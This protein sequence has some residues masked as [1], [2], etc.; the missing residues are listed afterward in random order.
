MHRL[1]GDV[2]RFKERL[3]AK[4]C[5]KDCVQ[6]YGIDFAPIVHFSTIGYLMAV[7]VEHNLEIDQMDTVSAFLQENWQGRRP[8][9]N[10]KTVL[11]RLDAIKS[12]VESPT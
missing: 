7:T 2:G 1:D 8:I 4:V 6:R 5:S 9:W 10:N 11:S 12:C 3:A